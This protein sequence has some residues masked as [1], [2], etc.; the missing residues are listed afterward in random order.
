MRASRRPKKLSTKR[1]ATSVE[2]SRSLEEWNEPTFSA[3]EWRSAAFEVL[4]ANG[5]CTWT[6]SSSTVPSSSSIVR[7]T[8]I[9]SADGAPARAGRDVE[10][11][12]DRDHPRRAAVGALEQALRVG[13]RGAQRLARL[14]HALL[15]VRRREHQHAVPAARE[16]ARDARARAR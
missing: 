5:S 3:R 2:S 4:G 7:A 10:H 11:L 16:L 6:K 9:G 8:S 14:A 12:A 1:R 13:A 15:R